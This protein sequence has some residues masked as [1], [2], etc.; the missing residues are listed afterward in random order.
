MKT[1]AI[2]GENVISKIYLLRGQK[3]MP[4]R[5]LAEMYGV[6]TRRLNEPSPSWE[7]QKPGTGKGFNIPGLIQPVRF[8]GNKCFKKNLFH[9]SGTGLLD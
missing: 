7:K 2:T 5:D 9:F 6:E 3:V 4:D 8:A 1:P